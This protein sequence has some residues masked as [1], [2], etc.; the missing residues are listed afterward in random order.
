MFL[1]AKSNNKKNAIKKFTS[2]AL[3]VL[4]MFC[5]PLTAQPL[6]T[7]TPESVGI[8]SERLGRIK[9]A[10][11][12]EV[13]KGNMPGGVLAIARHGK[14]AYY[15]SFGY[16]DR[17]AGIAMPKNAIFSISSLTKPVVA[18]AALQLH[19]QGLLLIN[20]PVGSYIPEL[21]D[22]RVAV[23]QDPSRTVE[24]K[25][26]PTVEDLFL[27]TSGFT[28][29]FM[30]DTPLHKAYPNRDWYQSL[31]GDEFVAELAKL[32]LYHQP[33]TT[34]D[35]SHG[36]DL[37][38]VMVERLSGKSHYAYLRDEI[39]KPLGMTE[40]TFSIPKN[41]LK[42]HAKPLAKDP[43]SGTPQSPLDH[44]RNKFDCGQDCLASTALD[45]VAFAQML[46]NKGELN[47]KRILGP[48]TVEYM[49]SDH[50]GPWIDLSG[51]YDIAALPNDGYG[52]GLG[53]AVR[54]EQGLGGTMAS[55]GEFQWYGATG[56]LFRVDPKE[57]LVIVFLANSP[58][59]IRGINRQ[60]VP[61]MVYQALIE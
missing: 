47:G 26:Q 25:R 20:Q 2:F 9:V 50:A 6:P 46:L 8:S 35:Y 53:V 10:M 18:V 48:K 42:R 36:F 56:T 4:G 33:G 61:T 29:A 28:N 58:G 40:T 15:E 11:D 51:L 1:L 19:E 5:G 7:A 3:L 32:P 13:E 39:F 16:L 12:R 31:T 38:A 60:L 37:L 44:S 21:K 45:Y 27:H 34:W 57:G 14:L 49:T 43:V 23:N 55:P 22:M 17:E 30:G 41:K 54:R 59:E 52:Y 24:A